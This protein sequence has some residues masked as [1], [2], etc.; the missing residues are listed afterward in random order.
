M[1]RLEIF[2]RLGLPPAGIFITSFMLE[3]LGTTFIVQCLYGPE[4]PSQPFKLIFNRCRKFEYQVT[5]IDEIDMTDLQHPMAVGDVLGIH[6][7]ED[8]YGAH[9]V[10]HTTDFELTISYDT[11]TIAYY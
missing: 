4:E 5:S 10:L 3:N 11:V 6:L 1:N 7:G 2:A 8:H 9:A